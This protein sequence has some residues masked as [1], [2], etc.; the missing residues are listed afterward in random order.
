MEITD[1]RRN[2]IDQGNSS[3]GIYLDLSKTFD[4]VNHDILVNKIRIYCIQGHVQTWCKSQLTNKKVITFVNAK[5]M[6]SNPEFMKIG[7]PQNSVL[8][9]LFFLVYEKDIHRCVGNASV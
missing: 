8:G 6:Y 7:R 5:Y 9:L 1:N 3:L 2:E 4:T